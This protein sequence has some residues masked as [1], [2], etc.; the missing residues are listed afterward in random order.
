[1][2]HSNHEISA[3][4]TAG[5]CLAVSCGIGLTAV[6]PINAAPPA[7]PA[8][9][10]GGKAPLTLQALPAEIE[11]PPAPPAA[12]KREPTYGS[13]SGSYGQSPSY[14]QN[15]GYGQPKPYSS[16]NSSGT[17]TSQGQAPSYGAPVTAEPPDSREQV[18]ALLKQGLELSQKGR[19]AEAE[20]AFKKA[21]SIDP[22]NGDANYNLGVIY[23]G[24]NQLEEAL[25][26]YKAAVS[27]NPYDDGVREAMEQLQDTINQRRSAAEKAASEKQ[28]QAQ[29]ALK[30]KQLKTTAD[31]ALNAYKAKNY[32]VA[33]QKFGMVANSAPNDPDVQYALGQC[34][35]AK[36]KST[37]ARFHLERAIK[38]NPNNQDYRK[39]LASI[40]NNP[41]ISSGGQT[42]GGP[43]GYQSPGY[44]PQDQGGYQ[45]YRRESSSGYSSANTP[46]GGY[47]R[48]RSYSSPNSGQ[49]YGQTSGG[50]QPSGQQYNPQG[51][52]APPS[53]YQTGYNPGGYNQAPPYGGGQGYGQQ[54]GGYQQ[55]YGGQYPPPTPDYAPSGNGY[56]QAPRRGNIDPMRLQR[57]V[58]QGARML[59]P[60]IGGRAGQFLN[61]GVLQSIFGN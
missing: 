59:S 36:G 57:A 28:A 53:G 44:Q 52:G 46:S 4:L 18:S 43:Q 38:L 34:W 5:L 27:A 30:M 6:L 7:K 13:S 50:Y 20:G 37:E 45:P 51:Y 16:P 47:G 58:S 35:L 25:K 9:K 26:Y 11:K 10:P 1:M 21:L 14:G 23:E 19:N 61:S 12:P 15:S 40:N 41:A 60:Y 31:E 42:S 8:A 32:D 17:Q 2:S 24:K 55:P 29:E 33:I 48:P 54:S 49:S 56:D 39:A 22:K 3:L